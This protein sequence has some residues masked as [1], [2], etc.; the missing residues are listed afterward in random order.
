MQKKPTA[1]ARTATAK[2]RRR[3]V[4]HTFTEGHLGTGRRPRDRLPADGAPARGGTAEALLLHHCEDKGGMES[5]RQ[6]QEPW[7]PE[8]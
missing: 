7:S 8:N 2:Q 1:T 4:T 6:D 3:A 5:G